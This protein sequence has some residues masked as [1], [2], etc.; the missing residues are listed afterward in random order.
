[1]RQLQYLWHVPLLR[2]T[3][4]ALVGRFDEA[5]RLAA[6]GR[7]LGE[8]AQHQGIA[9]FFPTVIAMIRYLPGRFAELA[10]PLRQYVERYPSIPTGR[11]AY[12][13]GLCESGRTDEARREFEPFAADDFAGLPRDFTWAT[14]LAFLALTCAALGDARRAAVLYELFLPFAPYN[15]RTTRIGVVCV[16][17]A[18]HYLGLLAATRQRLDDAVRHLEAALAMNAR[19][20]SPPFLA[21]SRYQPAPRPAH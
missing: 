3:Q 13:Y 16:G 7:A 8:R 4:A 6:E 12:A 14:N 11:S 10:D 20:G 2:A 17:A 1:L 9:V 15:V 21:I 19:R 18:A 5:E